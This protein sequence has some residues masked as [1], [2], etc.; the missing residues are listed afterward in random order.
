MDAHSV[1]SMAINV[2]LVSKRI[3]LQ[4]KLIL[5]MNP[6]HSALLLLQQ[7]LAAQ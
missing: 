1:V 7:H 4:I 3:F 2:Q 6:I 5:A